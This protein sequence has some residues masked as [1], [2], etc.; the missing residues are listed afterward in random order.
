MS[1]WVMTKIAAATCDNFCSFFETDVTSIFIRSS[2]LCCVRSRGFCWGQ[3]GTVSNNASGR[4]RQQR[5]S[6]RRPPLSA[7]LREAGL[8]D[9]T[10]SFHLRIEL[11]RNSKARE[12]HYIR[13][14]TPKG[15][16]MSPGE[17]HC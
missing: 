2:I 16:V 12:G 15:S 13:D 8:I 10:I 14:D 5:F 11:L 17:R 4:V 7:D 6:V 1:C 3:A 9:S